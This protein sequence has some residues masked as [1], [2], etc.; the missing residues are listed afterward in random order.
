M[1]KSDFEDETILERIYGLNEMFPRPLKLA[2]VSTVSLIRSAFST[3]KKVTWF[4]FSTASI[5][6]L[7]LSLEIE[8]QQYYEQI[9]RQERN[10]ILG[11]N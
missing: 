7:P 8:R 1:D 5:L 11:P 3:A 2:A 10:I 6:I 9:E 4:T